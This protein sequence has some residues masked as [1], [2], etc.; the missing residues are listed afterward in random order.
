MAVGPVGSLGVIL[1]VFM[2]LRFP[3]RSN[4]ATCRY[5][6]C[7]SGKEYRKRLGCRRWFEMR[8]RRSSRPRT[9][10]VSRASNISN[11]GT[12][13]GIA[14]NSPNSPEL[15][16]KSPHD[17]PGGVVLIVVDVRPEDKAQEQFEKALRKKPSLRGIRGFEKSMGFRARQRGL[18]FILTEWASNQ[19]AISFIKSDSLQL[20]GSQIE[21]TVEP[22]ARV[23]RPVVWR[24]S[25][26]ANKL[27]YQ[28]PS[29]VFFKEYPNTYKTVSEFFE[30]TWKTLPEDHLFEYPG[31]IR[32]TVLL[33]ESQNPDDMFD[34]YVVMQYWRSE[35][36]YRKMVEDTYMPM[37]IQES[38][39][40][41]D[42]TPKSDIF[43]SDIIQVDLDT[44]LLE[45][46]ATTV[47]AP[48]DLRRLEDRV[49]L[50]EDEIKERE[51]S[52]V[53]AEMAKK[54]QTRGSQILHDETEGPRHTG[55]RLSPRD[56]AGGSGVPDE[57][58]GGD[59]AFADL[60]D[61]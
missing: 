51:M 20:D 53:R 13:R 11:G 23:F 38:T 14:Y 6:S 24:E 55:R 15:S 12:Q 49:E 46:R 26:N 7:F 61:Y 43:A 8:N 1:G 47:T 10:L 31:F 18:Y 19:D 3:T 35:G 36:E 59:G 33:E 34:N 48:V 4:R 2:F 17:P 60:E 41:D 39:S 28:A 52:R 45:T 44:I 56:F 58:T 40:P 57:G 50:T 27:E 54:E 30:N 29:F 22:H 37:D 21:A 9:P 32:T 16:R 25:P 42:N 5:M